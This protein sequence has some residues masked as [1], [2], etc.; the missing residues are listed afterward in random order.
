[1]AAPTGK[2]VVYGGDSNDILIALHGTTA[3]IWLFGGGGNDVCVGGVGNDVLVGGDG[4]DVLIGGAGR[5]LLIGGMGSDYL[6]G[7]AGDDILIGGDT[8]HGDNIQA[9]SQ[10]MA[11]WTS[12][13][14]YNERVA[15][16]QSGGVN[17]VNGDVF[18]NDTTVT[19]DGAS[20]FLSGDGGR[21][22]FFANI[23]EEGVLDQIGD[24][25]GR[26]LL[27]DLDLPM[28]P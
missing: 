13:H 11:E 22:W 14:S 24:L 16:L 28:A 1:V 23:E 6:Y 27:A 2:I 19:D 21:D 26:E 15:N 20:D 3:P 5:D 12:G 7:T 10:I 17:R 8:E 25:T 9:L 18:L 4:D